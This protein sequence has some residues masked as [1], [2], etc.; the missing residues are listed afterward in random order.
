MEAIIIASFMH[1]DMRPNDLIG[2]STNQTAH[3]AL[4]EGSD[5]KMI[6]FTHQKLG[7]G[8]SAQK[9]ALNSR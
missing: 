4:I 7:P 5:W 1:L 3:C 9:S 2:E 6:A 8:G